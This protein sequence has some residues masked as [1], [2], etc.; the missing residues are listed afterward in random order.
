MAE[1]RQAVGAAQ[2]NMTSTKA[3]I[4]ESVATLA[5]IKNSAKDGRV[6]RIAQNYYD[7]YARKHCGRPAR[8]ATDD[9]ALYWQGRPRNV[10]LRT[11]ALAQ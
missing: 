4:A 11:N 9:F 3:F 6:R 7:C 1:L 2:I 10:R 8:P 5:D